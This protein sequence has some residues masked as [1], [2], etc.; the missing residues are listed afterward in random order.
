MVVWLVFRT[1][2]RVARVLGRA[3][4]GGAI[5]KVTSLLLAGIAVMMIRTAVIAMRLDGMRH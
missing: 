2:E 5:V 3:G 4:G 1:A